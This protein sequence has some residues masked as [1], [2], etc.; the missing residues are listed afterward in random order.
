MKKTPAYWTQELFD[1]LEVGESHKAPVGKSGGRH[2]AYIMSRI[3]A[4]KKFKSSENGSK[5]ERVK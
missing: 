3:L 2:G 4:P 5:V 1:S